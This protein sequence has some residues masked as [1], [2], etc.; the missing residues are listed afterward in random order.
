MGKNILKYAFR[1]LAKR[2]RNLAKRILSCLTWD[3]WHKQ[4][5]SQEGEDMVLSRIFQGKNTGFYVDV[6]A[7]HPKR[8]SNTHFFY[9]RNWSG[10]NIDAMPNSMQLFKKWRP[11]DINLEVGVAHLSG[12]LD[13]FVFNEPA[14]NGFSSELSSERDGA[15]DKYFIKEIVKIDVLPLA[16]IFAKHLGEK[17]IDFMSVD[18]EGLDFDVI[19]S[20][21]WVKYRPKI[22]LAEILKSTLQDLENDLLAKF[23]KKVGYEIFAKTVNTVFFIDTQDDSA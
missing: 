16:E 15:E 8:F 14:L 11:R 23:M 4:S 20:N 13:Y 9:R 5:W 6:G 1:N 2:I 19:K 12:T 21:D 7:H 18:V 10:I 3:Q 22:V 17:K